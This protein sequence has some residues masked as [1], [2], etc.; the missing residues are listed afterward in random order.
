MTSQCLI[1]RGKS[2][3]GQLGCM[4]M[5]KD[6]I[7][8]VLVRPK[9]LCTS[10]EVSTKGKSVLMMFMSLS[11]KPRLGQGKLLLISLNLQLAH[12]IKV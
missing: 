7:D 12:S 8:I 1:L 4:E 3:S 2:G 5:L 10:S 6:V 9:L 11:L